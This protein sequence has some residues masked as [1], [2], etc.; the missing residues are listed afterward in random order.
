MFEQTAI[1]D[2]IIELTETRSTN[3][4]ALDLIQSGKASDGIVVTAHYQSEGRGQQGTFWQSDPG[5]NLLV[6]VILNLIDFPAQ[7][8]F[9]LNRMI[10]VACCEAVQEITG[11]EARIKWP[12]DIMIK[13][14]K[15]AGI[16]VENSIRAGKITWCVAGIGINLNQTDFDP[17]NVPAT[18]VAILRTVRYDRSEG[19]KIL[20]KKMDE[21]Y[22]LFRLKR[23][24]LIRSKYSQSLYRSQEMATFSDKNG[25]FKGMITD[26]LE[27]GRLLITDIDKRKRIYSNKEVEFIFE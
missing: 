15:I 18:S 20:L 10:S 9:H 2:K 11:L 24:D 1:G 3:T 21:W 23:F 14:S 25:I 19:L 27:D 22:R 8:H 7:L 12:N 16:L 5:S 26:V 6:S 17:Y 4:V 13:D